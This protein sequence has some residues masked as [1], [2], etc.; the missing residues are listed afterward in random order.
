M[1]KFVNQPKVRG[2]L[3]GLLL[4]FLLIIGSCATFYNSLHDTEQ[5]RSVVT[6]KKKQPKSV[7]LFYK[8]TCPD[9]KKIF[10]Q[11]WVSSWKKNIQF[12][13]LN[14]KQNRHYIG[15]YDLQYVPTLIYLKNG[16]EEKR[17]VGNNSNKIKEIMNEAK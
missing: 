7:V 5:D 2:M 4:L 3:L 15:E 14:Q 12:V 8:D 1:K 13:N 16:K 6:I 9:C 11:V 17:Y 10:K